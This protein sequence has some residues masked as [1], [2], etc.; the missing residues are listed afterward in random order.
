MEVMWAKMCPGK[1]RLVL[2]G[3]FMLS[4]RDA[5]RQYGVFAALFVVVCR[6]GCIGGVIYLLLSYGVIEDFHLGGRV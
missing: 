6:E 2:A 5:A 3:V 1:H 4:C